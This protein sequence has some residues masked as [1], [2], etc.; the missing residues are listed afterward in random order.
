MAWD[1]LAALRAKK[2]AARRAEIDRRIMNR[3][4]HLWLPS[5]EPQ[6]PTETSMPT[7]AKPLGKTRPDFF[8]TPPG[9]PKPTPSKP[10]P[11]KPQKPPMPGVPIDPK[12]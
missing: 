8:E 7:S 4:R 3:A 11:P 6:P 10:T 12:K 1:E 2:E 5:N 9:S